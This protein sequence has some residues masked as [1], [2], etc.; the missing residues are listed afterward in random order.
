LPWIWT[1]LDT[2]TVRAH[3]DR[4]PYAIW[5]EQGHLLASPGTRLD[6]QLVRDVLKVQRTRYDIQAIGFDPWHA[7]TLITQLT[8]EDGFPEQQVLAVP[9]TYQ[10]M[11][12]PARRFEADVIAGEVDANNDPLMRWCASNTVVQRDGK[13]NIQPIKKKSRGRIDPIVATLIALSLHLK[14]P[15][16]VPFTGVVRNLADFL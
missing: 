7:D 6:H 9:Q 13:D 1:P 16:D 12:S 8:N 2:M 10:H 4:A 15:P 14:T 3:H 5:V 11:S